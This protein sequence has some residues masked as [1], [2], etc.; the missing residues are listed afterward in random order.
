MRLF[1]IGFVPR[2]AGETR[3]DTPGVERKLPLAGGVHSFPSGLP[4]SPAPKAA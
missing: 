2:L 4:I 3:L 1:V